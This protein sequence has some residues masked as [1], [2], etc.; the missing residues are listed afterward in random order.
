MMMIRT[1]VYESFF[2]SLSSIIQTYAEEL[3]KHLKIA[4]YTFIDKICTYKQKHLYM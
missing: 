3:K 1:Y 4:K 2:E